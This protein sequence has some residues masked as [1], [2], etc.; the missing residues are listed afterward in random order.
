MSWRVAVFID[1][2]PS[3]HA[4]VLVEPYVEML[5]CAVTTVTVGAGGLDVELYTE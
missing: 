3:R 4:G 2:H 1:V 5:I